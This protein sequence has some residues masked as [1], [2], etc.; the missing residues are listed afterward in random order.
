MSPACHQQQKT[1]IGKQEQQSGEQNTCSNHRHA[2]SDFRE[3]TVPTFILQ[4]RW[5]RLS[6]P[7]GALARTS[8]RSTSGDQRPL[9]PYSKPN[10]PASS[11]LPRSSSETSLGT[12]C[13]TLPQLPSE[14]SEPSWEGDRL[15][16]SRSDGDDAMACPDQADRKN[17]W[18]ARRWT[19]GW[20]DR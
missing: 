4:L 20:M 18:G 6:R 3:L 12:T 8:S 10:S 9:L 13:T 2:C 14:E 5:L 15:M 1:C 7:R 19:G 11:N 17:A 16:R